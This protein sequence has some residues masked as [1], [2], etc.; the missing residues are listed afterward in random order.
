MRDP[1]PRVLTASVARQLG[2]SRAAV[3][4]GI[5][6]HGWRQLA[7]GVVLTE[8]AAATRTDWALA[9]LAIAGPGGA[10]SGWDALRL[11]GRGIAPRQPATDDVLVLIRGGGLNR[12]IGQARIRPTGRPFST[13]CTS[14]EDPALPLI[15][16][17]AVARAVADTALTERW[18]NPVRAMVAAA[19]QHDL[20]TVDDLIAELAAA[21]RNGSGL[22]RRALAEIADGARS[23]AE[24]QALQYLRR[25]D[26]PPF[27]LN[28]PITDLTG[29][30]IAYADV[31]WP[32]LRAVLEIDSREYH[33]DADDWHKTMRRHNKVARLGYALTHYPPSAIGAGWTDEVETWLHARAAELGVPYH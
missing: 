19:V 16:V 33:F 15:D 13:W 20:C 26:V 5:T 11:V 17:V 6:R 10:L 12:R 30:V 23:A 8:P 9:G 2:V 7:R 25:A 28:A 31:L 3:R 24:A 32:Q 18:L 4:H 22:L 1:L 27:E 29:R 21:P 14:A